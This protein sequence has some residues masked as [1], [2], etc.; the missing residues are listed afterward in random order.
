M[1]N[2]NV[3]TKLLRAHIHKDAAMF[4]YIV[5]YFILRR[6]REKKSAKIG[7]YGRKYPTTV[8][9]KLSTF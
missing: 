7:I 9:L 5:H 6:T 2:M 3:T 4:S 8:P 1:Q